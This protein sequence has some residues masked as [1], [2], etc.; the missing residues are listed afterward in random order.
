[1][2][3]LAGLRAHGVVQD[4]VA[5]GIAGRTIFLDDR[6]REQGVAHDQT[7]DV[8]VLHRAGEGVGIE[9]IPFSQGERVSWVAVPDLGQGLFAGPR[10]SQSTWSR[11]SQTPLLQSLT[12][13]SGGLSRVTALI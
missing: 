7:L 11:L 1:M 2:P 3:R 13:H 6:D 10:T 8:Q 12:A 4:V 9:D 5:R